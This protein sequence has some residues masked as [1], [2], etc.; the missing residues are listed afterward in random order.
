MQVRVLTLSF[1]SERGGFDESAL[2]E[3]CQRCN[4]HAFREHLFDFEGKP[5]VACVVECT[6]FGEASSVA[7]AVG[8]KGAALDAMPRAGAETPARSARQEA[9]FNRI[10]AWRKQ[11]AEAR[12]LPPYVLFTNREL[13]AIVAQ[14]PNTRAALAAIPGVGPAKLERYGETLLGLIAD[15][16]PK[17]ATAAQRPTKTPSAQARHEPS[18]VSA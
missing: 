7:S 1:S 18:D 12:G 13:D 3:L 9:T 8:S 16:A 2:R 10:R 6:P 5:Y 15:D 17:P 14:M 11:E 4:V